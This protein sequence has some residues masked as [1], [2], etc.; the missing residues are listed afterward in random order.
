MRYGKPLAALGTLLVALGLVAVSF[1]PAV[2]SRLEAKAARYGASLTV[3]RVSP[4]WLG[5]R[6]GGVSVQFADLPGVKARF[7]DISVEL[8]TSGATRGVV[9]SRGEIQAQGSLDELKAQAKAFAQRLPKG[10]GGQGAPTP[11]K[12]SE[13]SARWQHGDESVVAAGVSLERGEQGWQ[14][15]ASSVEV[16]RPLQSV[17]L[18]GASLAV[19]RAEGGA[20]LLGCKARQLSVD[21]SLDGPGEE[22]NSD[23]KETAPGGSG[24]GEPGKER[25]PAAGSASVGRPA[26]DGGPGEL[27]KGLIRKKGAPPPKKED[28]KEAKKAEEGPGRL[29][30]QAALWKGRAHKAAQGALLAL[31]EG[32]SAEI[33]RLK[34][35]VHRGGEVLHVGPGALSLKAGARSLQVGLAPLQAAEGGAPLLVSAEVPV[36]E[37]QELAVRVSGG[38][39]TLAMLGVHE[40]DMGLLDVAKASV[41]AGGQVKLAGEAD[42]VEMELRGVVRALSLSHPKLST[43]PVRGLDL[44]FS[45]SGG[46][47]LDGSNVRVDRG[48][49]DVGKV[50]GEVSGLYERQGGVTSIRGKFAVPLAS[51]QSA[52]EA[53]PSGLAP[54]LAGVKMVGT[55]AVSGKIGFDSRHPDEALVE[56][57]LLNDC[58]VTHAPPEVDIGRFRQPFRRKVYD[59]NNKLVEVESGPGTPGWVS[60]AGITPHMEAA[61]MTT[62]DGGFRRHRGF[63]LEAIRNSIRE[64]LK[65]GRFVRGAST[66]SMQTAK[67]LYLTRDKTVGRKLQEAFFTMYLEQVLSKEQILELYLNSIEFGPMIYGIG[68]AAQHY[69][70][71]SAAELSLGQALYLSSILPNPKRQ[72]FGPDGKVSP[73][74]MGYLH[75]LMRGMAKRHL[76]R[77][78]ELEDGLTEWVTFGQPPTRG[79]KDKLPDALEDTNEAR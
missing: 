15:G 19:Q 25:P 7:D 54:K 32:S 48:E 42:R 58:R 71:T 27:G 70:H 10:D 72:F 55:F 56:F 66:I 61:V 38:P 78:D 21:V 26:G 46:G 62:E 64:N 16:K 75:R 65:A 22:K 45:W 1:G 30:K 9:A 14:V 29:Q 47:A 41:E 77:D 49:F 63:D 67:N 12:V 52:V 18:E 36:D 37:K 60:L 31:A 4:I 2:R 76:I 5:V 24:S 35:T 8:A 57:N 23:G 53:L 50:H 20:K 79:N 69:F 59:Q 6:L 13:I 3:E 17:S 28:P 39:V 74:F 33:E 34:V 51:C 11:V 73:S 44:S 68:P 43:E 40:G